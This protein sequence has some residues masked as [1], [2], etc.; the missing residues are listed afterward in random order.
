M[1]NLF[2]ISTIFLMLGVYSC[3]KS[4]TRQNID[5]VKKIRIGMIVDSVQI[6]MGKEDELISN[7]KAYKTDDESYPYISFEYDS[8]NRVSRIFSP[9][10]S[11]GY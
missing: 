4:K 10:N 9:T 5:N 6:I 3:T 1:K 11:K 2:K 8:L 7:D